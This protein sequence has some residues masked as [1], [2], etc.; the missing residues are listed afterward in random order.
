MMRHAR[1]AREEQQKRLK[2]WQK[3]IN[4]IESPMIKVEND[5]DL[6]GPP[7]HMTYVNKSKVHTHQLYNR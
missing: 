5:Y 1:E 6:E 2:D 7:R 4:A 3:E